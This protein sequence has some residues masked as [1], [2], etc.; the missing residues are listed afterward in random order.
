MPSV[1]PVG[2]KQVLKLSE[3]TLDEEMQVRSA[4]A[5]EW[6]AERLSEAVKKGAA[7]PK[8]QVIHVKEGEK[9][10]RYVIDGWHTVRAHELAGR[11]S[12]VCNVRPGT[13]EDAV[14]EAAKANRHHDALPLRPEDKRNAVRMVLAVEPGWSDKRIAAHL[15]VSDRFVAQCRD[16]ERPAEVVGTDGKVHQRKTAPAK[17]GTDA[18]AGWRQLKLADFLTASDPT[19]AAINRANLTTAGELYD[20]LRAGGVSVRE[21][22]ARD[23]MD[24]LRAL[25]PAVPN[26]AAVPVVDAKP[27]PARQGDAPFDWSEFEEPFG[28]AVRAIDRLSREAKSQADQLDYASFKRLA[29][30]V[31]EL[32]KKWKKR[33]AGAK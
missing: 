23:L 25:D 11:K 20:A 27:E 19:W 16:G 1:W 5:E 29:G 6:H 8:V 21:G 18:T 14:L 12:V 33:L 9:A 3:L 24:E 28:R 13:W 22:V 31:A 7:L 26:P 17:K 10:G 2:K 30:E 32:A 15:G 4:G